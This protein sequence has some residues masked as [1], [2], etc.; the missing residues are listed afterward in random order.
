MRWPPEEASLTLAGEAM[1]RDSRSFHLLDG[2]RPQQKI[3]STLRP[4]LS[5]TLFYFYIEIDSTTV[6][7]GVKIMMTLL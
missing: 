4:A 6:F 1:Q 3:L 2:N 5:S 7:A